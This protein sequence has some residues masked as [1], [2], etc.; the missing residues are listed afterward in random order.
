MDIGHS[1]TERLLRANAREVLGRWVDV[2]GAEVPSP[3]ALWQEIVGLGWTGLINGGGRGSDG[4]LL[5]LGVLV[6]ELG[7]TAV[8]TPFLQTSMVATA[9]AGADMTPAG[10]D[11]LGSLAAG[12]GICA[13][14]ASSVLEVEELSA[15]RELSRGPYLV[16]WAADSDRLVVPW[17]SAGEIRL[18]A[19]EPREKGVSIERVDAI[20]DE[21]VGRVALLKLPIDSGDA[22]TD[23]PLSAGDW[24]ETRART[25]L[26]RAAEMIGGA[27]RVVELTV[28]HLTQRS[29]FGRPLGTFQAVQHMCADMATKL[30]G[31]RLAV[32][33]GLWL[34]DAGASCRAAAAVAGYAAAETYEFTTL[35]AAQLHGG[36]GYTVEYPLQRYFRRAK[37][38]RLRQGP[39]RDQLRMIADLLLDPSGRRSAWSSGELRSMT[40]GNEA[41]RR[42]ASVALGGS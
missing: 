30:D 20:D 4:S 29:Q 26:L 14:V 18:C 23:R 27:S 1:E 42:A 41:A 32:Y 34:A 12:D 19:F 39:V 36:T 16:E 9:L 21:P 13:L 11:L 25:T 35:M 17:R 2:R 10:M 31:A 7:R 5:E 3:E 15:S 6:E 28:E 8:P 24:A 22:L 33:E 40:A 37:A 38:L